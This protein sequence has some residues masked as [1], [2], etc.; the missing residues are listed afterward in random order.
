MLAYLQKEP[1]Y[2]LVLT[3]LKQAKEKESLLLMSI[4]NVGELLY[5]VGKERGLFGAQQILAMINELPLVVQYADWEAPLG[6]A[7]LKAHYFLSYA[8]CFAAALAQQKGGM[9]IT[10]DSEFETVS[11]ISKTQGTKALY[12]VMD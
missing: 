3:R 5:I 10:G 2:D 8:D 7:H 4:V 1:G 12:S 9:L 6:A 11:H